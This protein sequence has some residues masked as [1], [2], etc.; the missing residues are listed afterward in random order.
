MTNYYTLLD[1]SDVLT[2]DDYDGL[3]H[4]AVH[5]IGRERILALSNTQTNLLNAS[6]DRII[7]RRGSVEAV[8]EMELIGAYELIVD[9][10]FPDAFVHLEQAIGKGE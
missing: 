4:K 9:H 2:Q 1:Y 7:N 3:S 5:V 6:L 10:V 8:T